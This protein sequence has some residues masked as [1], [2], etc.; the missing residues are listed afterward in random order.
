MTQSARHE[1]DVLPPDW[2]QMT[3]TNTIEDFR[4]KDLQRNQHLAEKTQEVLLVL[5]L[6]IEVLEDLRQHFDDITSHQNFP[7]VLTG[8]CALDIARF[9]KCIR[10]VEKDLR[11]QASRTETLLQLL[12]DRKAFVRSL[13]VALLRKYLPY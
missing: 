3:E 11:L 4:F 10:G 6:N 1:P 7:E 8:S 12:A 2:S 13:W 9:R 5:R